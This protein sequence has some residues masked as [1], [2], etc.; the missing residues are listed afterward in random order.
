[1]IIANGQLDQ[2]GA[3]HAG[4]LV[5]AADG[6][7]RHCL[8]LG[9]RPAVVIGDLDSLDEVDLARLRSAGAEIIRYP[10]R[11]DFTDL[12]LALDYAQ[13]RGANEALVLGA[14]GAR[15][16]HTI[17]NLLLPAAFPSLRIR[18]VDSRQEICLARPGETLEIHGLP[19]DT[20]S[21]IPLASDARGIVTQGLEY[22]LNDENLLF[23]S[24]RGV[25]NV[26]LGERAA[27]S[28]RDGLLLCVLIHA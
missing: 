25:S 18:L 13:R 24:T 23:G 11:K 26:L 8:R 9:I 4:D 1:V 3:L 10:S 2:P 5:I 6:G 14:L 22:P 17:A 28:L 7:A 16:D 19:G 15:W 20:L 12:E 21:L 27:I